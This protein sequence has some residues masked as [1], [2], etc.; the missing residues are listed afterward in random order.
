M[1]SSRVPKMLKAALMPDHGRGWGLRDIIIL[2]L[3]AIY[4]RYILMS[5]PIRLRGV[6]QALLDVDG[7]RRLRPRSA[8]VVPGVLGGQPPGPL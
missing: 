8:I 5:I 2:L 4:Y 7:E 6:L 3:T 1:V